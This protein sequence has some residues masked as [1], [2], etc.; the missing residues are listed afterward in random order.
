MF[1]LQPSH[2]EPWWLAHHPLPPPPNKQIGAPAQPLGQGSWGCP[3]PG[4]KENQIRPMQPGPGCPQETSRQVSAKVTCYVQ[5]WACLSARHGNKFLNMA[6]SLFYFL[7]LPSP[8]AL[9][10]HPSQYPALDKLLN[11]KAS[12]KTWA[13]VSTSKEPPGIP[14]ETCLSPSLSQVVFWSRC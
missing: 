13:P 3:A 12:W 4:T 8:Y 5:M 14:A 2:L 10:D 1:Y 9:A 11:T 7:L 6:T